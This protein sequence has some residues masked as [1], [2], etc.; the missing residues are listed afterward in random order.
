MSNYKIG[1]TV[2]F[3][4]YPQTKDAKI[5]PVEWIILDIK[6]DK[7]LLLSKYALDCRPY[8]KENIFSFVWESCFLRSWLNQV[9]YN[10]AF[11]QLEKGKIIARVTSSGNMTSG[12]KIRDN[13]FLLT[14]EDVIKYFKM[15]PYRNSYCSDLASGCIPTE[16]AIKQ[17]AAVF[18]VTEEELLDLKECGCTHISLGDTVGLAWWIQT[19]KESNNARY[20]LF[21]G[22]LDNDAYNDYFWEAAVRP[23]IWVSLK[24]D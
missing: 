1:E 19:P 9:F 21:D 6:D 22:F 15:K 24:P 10:S 18:D 8:E 5:E 16:Y 7:A 23:A 13:V 3:G 11:D 12:E 14:V 4:H 20:V 2:F 17:G